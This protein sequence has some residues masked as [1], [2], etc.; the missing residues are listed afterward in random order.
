MDDREIQI[1]MRAHQLCQQYTANQYT[2]K[3]RNDR[4]I[5]QLMKEFNID[6][7]YAKYCFMNNNRN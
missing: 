6:K 4:I 5:Y 1:K 7:E 3:S 2:A